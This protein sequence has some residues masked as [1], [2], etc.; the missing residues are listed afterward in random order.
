ML[1]LICSHHSYEVPEILSFEA[2][3]ENAYNAWLVEN[4]SL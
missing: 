2:K 1:N 3:A 4:L